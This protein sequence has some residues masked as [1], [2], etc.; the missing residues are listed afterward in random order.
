MMMPS[1][2][3]WTV[4]DV[5]GHLAHPSG[6]Y[7]YFSSTPTQSGAI[8]CVGP[9]SSYTRRLTS[10]DVFSHTRGAIAALESRIGLKHCY[11]LWGTYSDQNI[12]S[13]SAGSTIDILGQPFDFVANPS[14]RTTTLLSDVWR[15]KCVQRELQREWYWNDETNVIGHRVGL[16]FS[17][18]RTKNDLLCCDVSTYQPTQDL[19]LLCDEIRPLLIRALCTAAFSVL[20]STTVG[21]FRSHRKETLTIKVANDILLSA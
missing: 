6:L 7:A 4:D 9:F 5:S 19:E 10:A 16:R 17:F 20:S 11:T 21:D 1:D 2:S 14:F 13:P 8:L 18:S 12:D 3:V 15:E